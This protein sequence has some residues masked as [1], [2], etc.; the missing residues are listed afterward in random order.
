MRSCSAAIIVDS[1]GTYSRLKFKIPRKLLIP[2]KSSGGATANNRDTN[3]G[4]GTLPYS[5]IICPNDLQNRKESSR[6]QP[7]EII[8]TYNIRIWQS[9]RP[10]ISITIISSGSTRILTRNKEFPRYFKL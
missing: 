1:L 6:I 2:C 8:R 5:D 4:S 3:F 7:N 10:E 9:A